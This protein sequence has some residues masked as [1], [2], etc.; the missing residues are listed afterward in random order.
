MGEDAGADKGRTRGS[1]RRKTLREAAGL[2]G[3][4]EG[5]VRKRVA[6]GTLA[7]DIGA[8]GRRY[9]YLEA[10]EAGADTGEAAGA[11][12][13][14]PGGEDT[15]SEVNAEL[16]ARV[17]SLERSLESEREARRRADHIIA[18]LTERIPELEAPPQ[19]PQEAESVAESASEG[20]DRGEAWETRTESQGASSDTVS[21]G[22]RPWWRRFF[23]G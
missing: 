2:L 5:A 3:V 23:G 15:L 18:A 6:R 21:G 1:P 17:E 12:E 20:T 22:R 10:D 14:S 11:D 4:S 13:G 9:V 19:T 7:S 16:R 8:D